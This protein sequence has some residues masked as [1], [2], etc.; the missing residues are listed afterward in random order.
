MSSVPKN[1]AIA[2]SAARLRLA[3]LV[4]MVFV[5]AAYVA[6]RLGLTAGAIRF[7]ARSSAGGGVVG[8]QIADCLVILLG[9]ALWRLTQMLRAIAAGDLFSVRVVG[10]FRSFAFWLLLMALLGIIA[11]LLLELFRT[12]TGPVHRFAFQLELRDL[13]ALGVTLILFLVA[14]LLERARQIE[15][16]MREIV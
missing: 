1:D 13:L 6:G 16:E 5:A 15:D 10:A 2:R 7:E 4:T 12:Q 8:Q 11:P 3:V 14:R 9:V